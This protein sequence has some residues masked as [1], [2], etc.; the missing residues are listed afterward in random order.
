M[1]QRDTPDRPNDER[2]DNKMYSIRNDQPLLL[3]QM[4]NI[5]RYI[6]HNYLHLL[7][8]NESLAYHNILVDFKTRN[9]DT[10][11][12][13]FL[14]SR[15]GS[16]APEVMALLADGN[17]KF[18]AR[19]CERILTEDKEKVMLNLCP[20]CDTLCRTPLACLCP[21]SKCNHTWYETRM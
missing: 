10:K 3:Y 21:N 1:L 13:N 8:R 17:E 16:A 11:H 9:S 6:F 19:I 15:I 12:K 2:T 7:T 4:D 14:K 20:K 18:Y 5:C